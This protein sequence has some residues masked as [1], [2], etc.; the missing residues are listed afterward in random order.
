MGNRLTHLTP[1]WITLCVERGLLREVDHDH[2]PKPVHAE[3]GSD[4]NSGAG[5][6]ARCFWRG[7][8]VTF[9]KTVS[10]KKS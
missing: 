8:G 9:V 3:Q 6:S 5:E 10:S 7:G 4:V 2:F 1:S